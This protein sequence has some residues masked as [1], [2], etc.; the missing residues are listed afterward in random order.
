MHFFWGDERFVA[1]TDDRSNAK[2]A[3]E[4]LLDHVPV[5]KEQVYPMQTDMDPENRLQSYEKILHNYFDQRTCTFDLVL[6][7][8]GDNAH[9][10]SLF[11][12]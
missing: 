3:F 1:V 12:G 2:M 7:G 8:L 6:L 10:L 4:T 11:P 9:T 5:V